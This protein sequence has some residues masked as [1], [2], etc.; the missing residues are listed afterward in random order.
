MPYFLEYKWYFFF[1]HSLVRGV[2]KAESKFWSYPFQQLP[3]APFVG[4]FEAE[5]V[6]ENFLKEEP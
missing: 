3:V 1:L 4:P 2:T 6:S 5:A